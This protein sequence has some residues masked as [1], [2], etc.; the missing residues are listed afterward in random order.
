MIALALLVT[1][2][3]PAVL[4]QHWRQPTP[5]RMTNPCTSRARSRH[6]R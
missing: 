1:V 5:V 6:A 4:M 3:A 2:L